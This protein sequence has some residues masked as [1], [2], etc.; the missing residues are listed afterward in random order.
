[1]DVL[2]PK[3]LP[4]LVHATL[5]SR[6]WKL[7][8]KHNIVFSVANMLLNRIQEATGTEISAMKLFLEPI[9]KSETA[10]LAMQLQL[11]SSKRVEYFSNWNS[12][13][14][15]CR[16]YCMPLAGYYQCSLDDCYGRIQCCFCVS[17]H[18]A[19]HELKTFLLEKVQNTK[20]DHLF[21]IPQGK[22]NVV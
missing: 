20:L 2:L 4:K 5:W 13:T 21:S 22:Y 17:A 11:D 3:Q 1:M 15:C 18:N 10:M 14:T 7:P 12:S 9:W 6:Q 8:A 19:K 16:C